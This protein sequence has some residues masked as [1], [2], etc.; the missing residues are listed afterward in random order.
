[1]LRRRE[2][3][4][5]DS[6][7][8][9]RLVEKYKA[10][11]RRA[12]FWKSVPARSLLVLY[13]GIFWLFATIAILVMMTRA[14]RITSAQI[15]SYVLL[16]GGVAVLYAIV[17]LRRRYI[18]MLP[19]AVI[20]VAGFQWLDH[21]ISRGPRLIDPASGLPSQLQTLSLIGS[22]TLAAGY[23]CFFVFFN[24]EGVRYFGAH[25]E[26]ALARELHQA[27][28]PEIN[29]QIGGFE[30]YGASVPSGEVGG[31][32]VD[33]MRSADGWTAYVADVSGHGVSPGVLMAMFKATVHT[34]LLSGCDGAK[35]LDGIHQ[36]LY[37]LKT[38]KM[39]VTAGFLQER[40]GRLSLSLAGHPA[41]LRF[42]RRVGCT[43]E[44]PAQDLPLGIL[45]QQSFTT[46]EIDCEPGDI[47]LLLT[48]GITEAADRHGVELGV[49]PIKSG[50]LQWADLP[51]A[52]VFQNIRGLATS[53]GKQEDDQTDA[54]G[55]PFEL[56]LVGGAIQRMLRTGSVEMEKAVTLVML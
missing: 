18:L 31:D 53:L 33:L 8:I 38:H 27:L 46:R 43:S 47:L 29:Q 13:A 4:I 55:S 24:R 11:Q 12:E 17:A 20:Q 48:D 26:I 15:F 49:E 34:L 9:S 25:T 36:T 32:L 22:L 23:S 7:T 40:S 50:L 42:Q 6:A 52:Q 51:L 21:V 39:F 28:V 5:G 44:Y 10:Y 41:L 30:I 2:H 37:P 19:I 54:P 3:R 16:C 35:L 56:G 14:T 1:V 45:P